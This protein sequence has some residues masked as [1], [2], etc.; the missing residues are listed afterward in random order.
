V[1]TN[2]NDEELMQIFADVPSSSF[3]RSAFSSAGLPLLDGLITT[4][5]AKSKNEARRAISE[6]GVYINN[7]R[8]DNVNHVLTS[9]DLASESA[10]VLRKGKKNYAVLRIQ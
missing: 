6:G 4:G 9:T 7:N 2:L 1:I 8:V 5:L 10:I 3:E